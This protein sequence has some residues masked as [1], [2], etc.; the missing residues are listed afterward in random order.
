MVES[1]AVVAADKVTVVPE[2]LTTVVPA[3]IPAPP[4]PCPTAIF[5]AELTV[6]AVLPDSAVPSGEA[7][8]VPAGKLKVNE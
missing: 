1:G 5:Y 7:A 3:A 8:L 2:I 4:T 6:K